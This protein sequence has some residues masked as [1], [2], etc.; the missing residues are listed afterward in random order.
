MTEA[1]PLSFHVDSTPRT[2]HPVIPSRHTCRSHSDA[3]MERE[4]RESWESSH[5]AIV[6]FGPCLRPHRIPCGF[7]RC[8]R[9]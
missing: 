1:P 4:S 6:R 8:C 9:C 5:S 3:K 2:Y 7:R